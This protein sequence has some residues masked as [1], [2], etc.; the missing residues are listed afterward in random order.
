MKHYSAE[1]HNN[2]EVVQNARLE[3]NEG[4][5]YSGSALAD[6]LANNVDGF[7]I[8]GGTHTEILN[9]QGSQFDP[10][11]DTHNVLN[12][13]KDAV[14]DVIAPTTRTGTSATAPNVEVRLYL[15][16]GANNTLATGTTG[17]QKGHTLDFDSAGLLPVKGGEVN[18]TD[19]NFYSV[20]GDG[21]GTGDFD[22]D[23]SSNNLLFTVDVSNLT[24]GGG[25]GAATNPTDYDVPVKAETGV[26][27]SFADSL[28]SISE[29]GHLS[30][31]GLN[32]V[33]DSATTLTLSGGTAFTSF[34]SGQQ[35]TV[36]QELSDGTINTLAGTGVTVGTVTNATTM[37]VNFPSG[38]ATANGFEDGTGNAGVFVLGTQNGINLES[39][40]VVSGDL[41]VQGDQTI[42]GSTTVTVADKYNAVNKPVDGTS[43]STLSVN[44]NSGGVNVTSVTLNPAS[45]TQANFRIIHDAI[46]DGREITFSD[47]GSNN[48]NITAVTHNGTHLVL[49]LDAA[50]TVGINAHTITYIPAPTATEDGGTLVYRAGSSTQF[51]SGSGRADG[52]GAY[53][54]IRFNEGLG[55]WQTTAGTDPDGGTDDDWTS[56]G[57]GAGTTNKAV[58]NVASGSNTV[59]GTFDG[60][61]ATVTA[62]D[63]TVTDNT[64]VSY[65]IAIDLDAD[66]AFP[67]ATTDVIVSVYDG[68]LQIIPDE[69]AL[70]RFDTDTS[71]DVTT[72]TAGSITVYMPTGFDPTTSTKIVIIG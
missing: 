31:R 34:T 51:S 50:I 26:V 72:A 9:A 15:D 62:A 66:S 46:E 59:T 16:G 17:A 53:A 8:I 49:T 52:T 38:E 54:G 41:T 55:E 32:I 23:F 30:E 19:L 43:T 65:K 68:G 7:V 27:D 5:A 18:G 47:G 61:A 58:I 33:L 22:A 42:V 6:P 60:A 70:D 48:P 56:I 45:S 11:A 4:R 37:T 36:N 21:S 10:K 63:V 28:I 35:V 29:T 25:S 40:V 14:L 20:S 24:G 39:D 57:S 3:I 1:L 71:A 44:P 2:N 64:T 69:V 67:L 12:F 13:V